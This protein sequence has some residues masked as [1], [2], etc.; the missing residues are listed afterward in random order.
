MLA[1]LAKPEMLAKL[2]ML[3]RSAVSVMLANFS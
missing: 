1:M 3:A 2:G